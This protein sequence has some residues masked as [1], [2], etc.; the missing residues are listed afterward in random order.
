MKTRSDDIRERLSEMRNGA[1]IT[2]DQELKMM[3]I[4]MLAE[5][6]NT[7]VFIKENTRNLEKI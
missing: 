3:E 5:L 4:E 7:L 6:N 1:A 2:R